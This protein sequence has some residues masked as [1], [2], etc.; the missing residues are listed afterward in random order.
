MLLNNTQVAFSSLYKNGKVI[1]AAMLLHNFIVE[2]M[3]SEDWD[4]EEFF[5]NFATKSNTASHLW[6][7]RLTNETPRALVT[8]T[9]E[10]GP[11]GRVSNSKKQL[12]EE[13]EKICNNLTLSMARGNL[14]RPLEQGMKYNDQGL[15]YMTN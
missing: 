10:P 5:W 6:L 7:T 9:N 15:I 1:V 8:N 13:G 11:A 4:E 14:K 12:Q 3:M 2:S